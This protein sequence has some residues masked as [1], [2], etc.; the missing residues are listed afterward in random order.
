M[1]RNCCFFFFLCQ[2]GMCH[3]QTAMWSSIFQFYSDLGEVK[4][5]LIFK[6][7]VYMKTYWHTCVY[8]GGSMNVLEHAVVLPIS[9]STL[10][11]YKTRIKCF[12][13]FWFCFSTYKQTSG[14]GDRISA[15]CCPIPPQHCTRFPQALL[16]LS[17][18][19]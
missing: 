17:R 12:Y 18:A 10:V 9:I 14:D 2:R 4:S 7:Y 19:L 13:S 1:G 5:Q 16:P 8:E 11:K 6:K 3:Q 15:Q